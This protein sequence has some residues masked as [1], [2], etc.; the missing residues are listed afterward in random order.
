MASQLQPTRAIGHLESDIDTNGRI[1]MAIASILLIALEPIPLQAQMQRILNLIIHLPWLAIQAKGAIYLADEDA[2]ELT[3]AAQIGLPPQ[4]LCVAEKR[5]TYGKCLCGKAILER[6]T[7]FKPTI[8]CDHEIV[9]TGIEPHGHYCVPILEGDR[10][11]G[12]LSL[13]L[14]EGHQRSTLEEQ[15]VRAV[16]DVIA[17]IIGRRRAEQELR[18][19]DAA[20]IAAQ[21]IQQD[22]LPRSPLRLPGCEIHGASF[23]A[24][25]TQG[26]IYDFF[27]LPDG[28]VIVV[29]ADVTGHG[30]DSALLMA[31][32]QARIRAYAE[33]GLGLDEILGR[34]NRSLFEQ[35]AGEHF[36][37]LLAMRIDPGARGLVYANA[38]HSSG[39]VLD[40]TGAVRVSLESQTLPI[41]IE[42]E[43]TFPTGPPL[44][45]AAGDLVLLITDGLFEARSPEGEFFGM[46]R[47]LQVVRESI[48]APVASILQAVRDAVGRFRRSSSLDDDLTLILARFH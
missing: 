7:I 9:Y 6:R 29:I 30:I 38:G 39:L 27:T 17:G 13:Y 25:R 18:L 44:E 12:L 36:V 23:P 11:L 16:S 47:V 46:E 5:I 48:D 37:T 35:T 45:L 4:L 19:R 34:V 8:D 40:R 42:A 31:A 20:L 10:R 32:T 24:E 15:F 21:Q 43:T 26:D 22:L 28:S 33:L 1:H 41:A 2:K 14:Q 3:I